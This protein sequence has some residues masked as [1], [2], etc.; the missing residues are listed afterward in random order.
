MGTIYPD[1]LAEGDGSTC[2]LARLSEDGARRLGVI[3][4]AAGFEQV[5]LI[6]DFALCPLTAHNAAT[7]RARLPWLNP[8]P[9]G[10]QTSFGFGDRIGCATPGHVQ[11]LR[12]ADPSGAVAPIFAQQS[13]RENARTGRT[14]QEVLDDATWGVIQ[15][16]WRGP[17]GAD[18]D[19]VKEVSDLAPFVAAGYTFYTV[20]P[21]DH[22]DNAAQTDSPDTLRHKTEALPW[23][24]LQSSYPEMVSRYCAGS[25]R[26][27][28]LTLEFAEAILSRA[29][30]KYGRALAHTVTI[31]RELAAR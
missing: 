20:D 15:V 8:V 11:A 6:E 9:L 7:L 4:D 22:V 19:H 16:G 12:Q 25:I 13:V 2:F 24:T 30:A 26:L 27:D 31:A 21:S 28:S 29:L 23:D 10:M 18:A 14:P 5:D 3:G 1:S 17:W